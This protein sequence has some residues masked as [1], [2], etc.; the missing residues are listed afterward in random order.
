MA[1]MRRSDRRTQEDDYAQQYPVSKAT[2]PLSFKELQ[3]RYQ[4]LK[5]RSDEMQGQLRQT[6]A[7]T[8][9]W[10]TVVWHDL[11]QQ[12]QR[13]RQRAW[14]ALCVAQAAQED[15][16]FLTWQYQQAIA[17]QQQL[18]TLYQESQ[19]ELSRV[20]DELKF[21]R[22]S[23]ASIKGWET[24]RKAENDRLKREIADMARVLQQS[25]VREG[26]ATA[27]L[28]NLASRMD[29]IQNLVD[30]LDSE[31]TSPKNLLEKFQRIWQAIR[32]ILRE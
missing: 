4:T 2:E 19:Q 5:S 27:T 21:E 13:E 23:K 17:G 22:R 25:M 11:V 26:E 1:A 6:Q 10:E 18:R 7:E 20:R 32:E 15:Q 30:G 14:N 8:Q 24:R 28:R 16:R 12:V 9:V 3:Q 29:R 31:A